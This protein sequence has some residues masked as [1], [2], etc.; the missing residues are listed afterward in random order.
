MLT[1]EQRRYY[2]SRNKRL[3]NAARAGVPYTDR[4]H[5]HARTIMRQFAFVRFSTV[6]VVL[7]GRPNTVALLA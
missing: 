5:A 4:P 1:D 3:L 6:P 7:F 2:A